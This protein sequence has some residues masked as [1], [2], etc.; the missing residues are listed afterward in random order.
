MTPTAEGSNLTTNLL[1][2]RTQASSWARAAA[3]GLSPDLRQ[4]LSHDGLP[5]QR[6]LPLLIR[7]ERLN[8]CLSQ[9][10]VEFIGIMI[11]IIQKLFQRTV[12]QQPQDRSTGLFLP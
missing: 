7:P 9:L 2:F 4:G 11:D 10:A 12:L 6:D 3:S 8:E 1:F 5:D